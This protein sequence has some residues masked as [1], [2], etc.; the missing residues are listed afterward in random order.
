MLFFNFASSAPVM[1]ACWCRPCLEHGLGIRRAPGPC[2][3]QRV[4][5]EEEIQPERLMRMEP[6]DPAQFGIEKAGQQSVDK[7]GGCAPDRQDFASRQHGFQNPG[8][9]GSCAM[10]GIKGVEES[11]HPQSASTKLFEAASQFLDV[12]F[13]PSEGQRDREKK[14]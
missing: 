5:S 13:T 11:L 2:L 12:D 14:G 8:T 4:R 3:S 7:L 9:A 10:E 1:F 6:V